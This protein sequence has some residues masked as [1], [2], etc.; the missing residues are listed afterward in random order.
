MST[1][2]HVLAKFGGDGLPKKPGA[3][4]H[5]NRASCGRAARAIV[6][7]IEVGGAALFYQDAA[8]IAGLTSWNE[9]QLA[10]TLAL[11]R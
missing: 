10:V 1:K 6:R 9:P 3:R 4:R 2:H 5:F 8:F 11:S 7:E